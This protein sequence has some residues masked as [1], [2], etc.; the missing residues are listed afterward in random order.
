MQVTAVTRYQEGDR[1]SQQQGT[2]SRHLTMR[3][4]PTRAS[5]D[6]GY[7]A[8]RARG[9]VDESEDVGRGMA[10]ERLCWRRVAN[11]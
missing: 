4:A 9:Q 8:L 2:D 10:E 7:T 3:F 1:Q 6:P 5:R 11:L